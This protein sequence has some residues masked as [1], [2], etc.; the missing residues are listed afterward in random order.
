MKKFL[1]LLTIIGAVAYGAEYR[2]G[3]Y[4]GVYISGQETQVEVQFDLKDDKV[5][6]PKFRT[7]FY[8]DQDY[9]KNKDLSKYKAEYE[10][11]LTAIINKNVNDGMETLYAPGE[12]ENAGATVRATK[13]RA[14]IKNALNSGVYTPAK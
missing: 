8:K 12:I 11:L 5:E 14:A 9:L 4:R 1:M 2:N 3:T 7:L 10:A 13:V 6:K